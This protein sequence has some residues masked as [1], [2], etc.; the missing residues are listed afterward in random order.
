VRSIRLYA[1]LSNKRVQVDRTPN[2][3]F[4]SVLIDG[5]KPNRLPVTE[6]PFDE[7]PT[8]DAEPAT[9]VLNERETETAVRPG[10]ERHP[11]S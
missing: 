9:G 6:I 11:C 7:K 1:A 8:E 10:K 4:C 5:P 2:G 3:N